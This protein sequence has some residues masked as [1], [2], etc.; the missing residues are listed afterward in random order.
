LP[1]T[2]DKPRRPTMITVIQREIERWQATPDNQMKW[3]SYPYDVGEQR[4]PVSVS[5]GG[6]QN[7]A[8]MLAGLVLQGRPVDRVQFSDTGGEKRSTMAFVELMSDWLEEQGY[9]PVT[10]LRYTTREGERLTLEENCLNKGILPS[11]A[12]GFH[13]KKCSQRWKVQVLNKD[14][15]NWAP[16]RRAWDEGE[17]VIKYIGYDVGEQHRYQVH[18]D[19]KYI[20]EYPLLQD[21]KWS[22][23][24]CQAVL[25]YVGLP[26]P[27]KSA[28]FFCPSTKKSEILKMKEE[29]PELLE[30]ALEMEDKAQDN[31]H[32][33]KGLGGTFSWREF[34]EADASQRKLFKG[35]EREIA[36]MCFDGQP[37]NPERNA[38]IAKMYEDDEKD[39]PYAIE[40]AARLKK[41]AEQYREIQRVDVPVESVDVIQGSF[42]HPSFSEAETSEAEA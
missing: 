24:D 15:N 39:L 18:D 23:S 26:I 11:L 41:R 22:R 9:P 38:M 10:V 32:T 31:L 42:D 5:F 4:L 35:R 33:I 20:Y 6:G 17:C 12:Y 25:G 3:P 14:M 13:L 34:V 36:C 29:N 28:C 1:E 27:P 40:Q 8:A 37:A 30:R 16:A 21:W 2:T 7:S 19:E